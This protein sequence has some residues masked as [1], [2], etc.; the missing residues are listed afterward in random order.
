MRRRRTCLPG[1]VGRRPAKAL[2]TERNVVLRMLL[3]EFDF[4][5]T[6]AREKR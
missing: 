4:V 2:T 3:R 6:D 5:P 1:L